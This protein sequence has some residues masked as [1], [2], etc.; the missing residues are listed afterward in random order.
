MV[1]N[2]PKCGKEMIEEW[3]DKIREKEYDYEIVA[4]CEHCDFDAVFTLAINPNNEEDLCYKHQ[5]F[6]G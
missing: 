6:F 1:I 3:R 2:C 4:H 5:F